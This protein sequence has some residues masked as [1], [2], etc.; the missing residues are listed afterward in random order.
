MKPPWEADARYRRLLPFLFAVAAFVLYC[1]LMSC[2]LDEW[3]S[4]QLALGIE[5]YD[6]SQHTAHPPGY[7]VYVFL[8]RL[9]F[10]ILGSLRTALSHHLLLLGVLGLEGRNCPAYAL[11][12]LVKKMVR[13]GRP[14]PPFIFVQTLRTRI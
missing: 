6:L 7:P 14:R 9:L 5:R 11:V 3:D 4:V 12:A 10:K 13:E 2:S 1:S 8:G